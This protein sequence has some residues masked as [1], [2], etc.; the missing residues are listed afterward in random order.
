M[1]DK[2]VVL[3]AAQVRDPHTGDWGDEMIYEPEYRVVCTSKVRWFLWWYWEVTTPCIVNETQA[4]ISARVSAIT[5]A[6][7]RKVVLPEAD[8]RVL[9]KVKYTTLPCPHIYVH[10]PTCWCIWKNGKWID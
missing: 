5:W 6:K 8:I 1:N 9:V 3:Y 10:R 2:K 4:T 7:Y